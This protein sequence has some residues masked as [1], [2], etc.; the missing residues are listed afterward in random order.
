[1]K[2]NFLPPV[3]L[4]DIKEA[5]AT[6]RYDDL[7]DM[8]VQPLH[9]ELYRRQT[10]EMLDE[11]SDGQQLML[12]YDYLR[13]QVLQGG[14]IQFIH[15]GY[16]GL[17]PAMIAQLTA[18]GAS[19]MALVLD[20]V[21]KVYVLNREILDKAETVQEF[22]QLYEELKEFE[23]IDERFNQLNKETI[24][25]MLNYAVAHLDEFVTNVNLS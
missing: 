10:F 9:E 6:G 16:L 25:T 22:A 4:D 24:V 8:L 13:T 12:T 1:M 17:L 23:G 18:I 2:S 20:D 14:F 21:L 11:L 19:E 7:Y 15:N 5:Q 3:N